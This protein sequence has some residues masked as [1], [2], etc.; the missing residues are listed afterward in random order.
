M[1]KQC[2]IFLH[3]MTLFLQLVG[4]YHYRPNTMQREDETTLEQQIRSA[5]NFEELLKITY[6]EDWKLWKCRLKLQS[7]A[8][9]DSRTSSHRSTRFAAAFYDLEILKDIDEEWQRTQC[10]PREDCVDVAKELGTKTNT[11]FKPRCVSVFRCGGC[12]NEESL[13]CTNT[14]TSYVTK[15]LFKIS[16]PLNN[17]P[18]PVVV[19]VANHTA[20]KCLPISN[21]H[22]HPYSIIRRS[23]FYQEGDR[24][25]YPTED[26]HSGLVWDGS[27]CQCV[28]PLEY[29]N[30]RRKEEL[31]P[32][33]E[34]ALCGPYMEFDEVLCDCVCRKICS[35]HQIQNPNN[36]TCECKES[37]GSCSLK[38]K[39][40]DPESC[41][42]MDRQC[43]PGKVFCSKLRRCVKEKRASQAP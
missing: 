12:C 8:T 24:C 38:Q 9:L 40:F 11:F 41:S 30:N 27:I 29:P 32:I 6:S 2:C 42:C 4:A 20:C 33:A 16:I 37:P 28:M 34:L 39:M 1:N 10:M 21:T 5:S 7:L 23:L 22:R 25:P 13:S 19:E 17:V 15:T 14:S 3:F 26:C 36:C 31:S 35:E 18:E 43:P